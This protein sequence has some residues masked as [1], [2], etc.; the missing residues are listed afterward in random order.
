MAFHFYIDFVSGIATL[1]AGRFASAQTGAFT[2]GTSY[3]TEAAAFAATN[4]PAAGDIMYYAP[5]TFDSGSVSIS[6]TIGNLNPP[7]Q[8]ICA[9]SANRDAYRT[10]EAGRA[11]QATTSGVAADISLVGSR[12]VYGME[13]SSVDN[14]TITNNGG[15]TSF[16]DCKFEI[17]NSGEFFQLSVQL[18]LEFN[19]TEF[20]M[21][22]INATFFTSSGTKSIFN[23]GAITTSTAGVTNLF[24]AGFTSAGGHVEYNGTN[25]SVIIGTLVANAGGTISTDD[26]IDFKFDLCPLANGVVRANETFTSSGQRVETRRC[27]SIS[28]AAEYQYGLTAL[29]GDV[30]DDSVISRDDDPAFADSATKIS[31]KVETN[32]SANIWQRSRIV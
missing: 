13:Y 20:A 19:D 31:Y 24:S 11:K 8:Q 21:N 26:Q 29:G 17:V 7:I 10:T 12:V 16:N 32:S 1:D 25:L 23:R 18:P 22:A 28:A 30:E 2:A 14:F 9:D 6:N 3:A 5:V 15:V 27:S 4:P